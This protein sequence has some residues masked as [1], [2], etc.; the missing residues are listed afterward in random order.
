MDIADHSASYP[1]P[2]VRGD[3][4]DPPLRLEDGGQRPGRG[5]RRYGSDTKTRH[6][7]RQTTALAMG[8]GPDCPM[9]CAEIGESVPPPYAELIGRAAMAQIRR[10]AA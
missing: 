10:A 5:A 9:T 7:P 1:G 6:V 8:L 3:A 4:L 2:F